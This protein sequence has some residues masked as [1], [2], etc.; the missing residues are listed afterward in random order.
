MT[1]ISPTSDPAA[2]DAVSRPASAADLETASARDLLRWAADRFGD[3]LVMTSSFGAQSAAMLHLAQAVVPG[4]PVVLIDTGYLF[5]ETYRF[6]L[7]LRDRLELNLKVVAPKLTPA[8]L[9]QAHGRLWEHGEE[10]LVRYHQIMKVEPLQRALREFDATAWV[11][12]V[13]ADQT[14]H[15][16]NLPRVTE[17]HG[18]TKLHPILH[19]SGKDVH[20]YMAA[21]DLLGKSLGVSVADLLGGAA[22]RR[23]PSYYATGVGAPD[24]IARVAREKRDE[25]NP[26]LQIKLGGCPV[27]IDIEAIGGLGRE[28]PDPVE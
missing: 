2:R 26:R 11:A 4:I 7:D 3:G 15:R 19:W 10:G 22:T 17:Q 1:V 12:G 20:D 8:F 9:E 5:P 21:H 24:E 16:A 6:A 27:E 14:D 28:I 13:R 25:G 18:L 23:V